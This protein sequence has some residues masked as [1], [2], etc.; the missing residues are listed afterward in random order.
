MESLL[1]CDARQ[2]HRVN[3]LHDIVKHI[4]P[5]MGELTQV[6]QVVLCLKDWV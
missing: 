1:M 3:L 6:A 4:L 2:I 5:M